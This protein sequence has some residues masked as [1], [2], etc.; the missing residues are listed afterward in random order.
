MFLLGKGEQLHSVGQFGAVLC[1]TTREI[2]ITC[3]LESSFFCKYFAS[4]EVSEPWR[5]K[6]YLDNPEKN[7]NQID[8]FRKQNICLGVEGERIVKVKMKSFGAFD[9]VE[10]I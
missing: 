8:S 2:S 5:A 10:S 9:M 7:N 1:V 6:I 3:P 4:Q